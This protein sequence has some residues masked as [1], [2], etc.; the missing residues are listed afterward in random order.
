L[1]DDSIFRLSIFGGAQLDDSLLDREA[2]SRLL[3]I[4][5]ST[6]DAMRRDG[7]LPPAIRLGRAVR[8]QRNDLLDWLSSRRENRSQHVPSPVVT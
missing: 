8:W 5:V 3:S 4:S 6:L 2:A 1:A 7:I